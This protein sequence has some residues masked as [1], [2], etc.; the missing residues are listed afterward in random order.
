MCSQRKGFLSI[1][2]AMVISGCA[3]PDQKTVEDG[4][5]V[6]R[7]QCDDMSSMIRNKKSQL[8]YYREVVLYDSQGANIVEVDLKATRGG[9]E[10]VSKSYENSPENSVVSTKKIKT[11]QI[12]E[13]VHAAID[14][15]YDEPGKGKTMDSGCLMKGFNHD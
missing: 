13:E 1:L 11:N 3:G 9:V 12:T 7:N 6:V 5:V 15:Y 8:H 4:W 10:A 2:V 14:A